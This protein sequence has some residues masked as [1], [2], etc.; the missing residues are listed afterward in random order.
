MIIEQIFPNVI[1]EKSTLQER[2]LA[3]GMLRSLSNEHVALIISSVPEPLSS[4]GSF[5]DK[6]TGIWRY[7]FGVPYDIS[8]NFV[9]GTHMWVPVDY[10]FSALFCAYSR[11]QQKKFVLYLKRLAD[12][13]KHQPTLVEMIPA[14]RVDSDV[15]MNF[16]VAGLG[17]G[18]STVDWEIG[19]HYG[20]TV[21]IDVKRRVTDFIK[22]AEQMDA[23]N[24]DLPPDHD[25]ALLFRSTDSKFEPANPDLYLQGLWIINDIKQDENE[26]FGAFQA[27]DASKIHFAILGDWKSDAYI[28]VQRDEDRQYLSE[29]F[30]VIPSTRFTFT[31]SNE[32]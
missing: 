10:L 1:A 23:E 30:N 2:L 11:L 6:M 9:C 17:H 27:L 25:P 29:L 20:R 4:A 28:L 15:L 26:L 7:E 22:H 13:S 32:D 5:L 16:E 18:N 12:P 19:P 21:L 8:E 24:S 14:N 31:R 3:E